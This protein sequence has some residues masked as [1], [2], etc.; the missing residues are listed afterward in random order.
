MTSSEV[1][2]DEDDRLSS[3]GRTLKTLLIDPFRQIKFGIYFIVLSLI[4]AVCS[5]AVFVFAFYE[6]Y[7]H[8]LEVF[9]VVDPALQWEIVLDEVF[10]QNILRVLGF[11]A[12]FLIVTSL[13]ML[14]L[15][16]RY[17]GP[18][19]SIERFIDELTAGEYGARVAIRSRDE[20][21]E[22]V[23]KLNVLASTLEHRHRPPE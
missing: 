10:Y 7:Q 19:V 4:F 9:N 11:F 23:A 1:G 5:I 22:L 20:L 6:Q 3:P 18:L 14:R 17:Y 13:V 2:R 8:L 16:H 21:Q 15:T 12:L